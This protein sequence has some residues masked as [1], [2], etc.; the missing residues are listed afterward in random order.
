MKKETV[1]EYIKRHEGLR[2][3]PYRDTVGL[4]TVGYGHLCQGEQCAPI[5][6]EQAEALFEQDMKKARRRLTDIFPRWLTYTFNRQIALLDMVFNLGYKLED[7]KK[8]RAHVE[9]GEW[10]EAAEEFLRSRW[11]R[12]VGSRAL[13]NASLLTAEEIP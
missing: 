4:L 13:E 12:Q 11:A 3:T 10:K 9:L 6:E 8:A 1:E 7:F 2:L 5:T